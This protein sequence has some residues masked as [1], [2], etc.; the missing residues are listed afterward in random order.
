M[1]IQNKIISYFP[2]FNSLVKK[3]IIINIGINEMI[4]DS[5]TAV[6]YDNYN[7]SHTNIITEKYIFFFFQF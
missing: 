3:K 4:H 5:H 2:F 1:N 7:K 6:N